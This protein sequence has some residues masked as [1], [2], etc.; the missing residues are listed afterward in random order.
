MP[1]PTKLLPTIRRAIRAV[2]DQPGRS[3]H[4]VSLDRATDVIV[5]GDLHGHVPNLKAILT[6]ANL[7]GNPTRHL[8]LQELIHGKFTY[9]QGGEKSHQLVDLFCALKCQYPDRVHY[10]PGNHEFAQLTNRPIGKG[11]TTCNAEFRFGVET[12][13][14]VEPAREIY[15]EY[16]KLFNA[17]PLSV[18][19]PNRIWISHSLPAGKH[20]P[21]FDASIFTRESFI[22]ADYLPG[23]SIYA[24]VWGRDT[25]EPTVTEYL[26]RVQADRLITGHIPLESGF[27]FPTPNHLILDCSASPSAWAIVP[28]DRAVSDEEWRACPQTF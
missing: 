26:K 12:A 25:S 6:A 24:V 4:L 27:Q 21:T 22:P 19:L 17:L 28:A 11:D 10:L 18:R 3:G 7:A 15:D 1:D 8:I 13:Y 16:M 5:A 2:G 23:G 20:L 9:P 14:G